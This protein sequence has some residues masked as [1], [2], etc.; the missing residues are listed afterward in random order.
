MLNSV[1]GKAAILAP[2]MTITTAIFS[3]KFFLEKAITLYAPRTVIRLL[4]QSVVIRSIWRYS[5]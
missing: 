5:M 3:L 1:T 2:M 4:K